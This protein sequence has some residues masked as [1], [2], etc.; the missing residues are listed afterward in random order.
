MEQD[1][2]GKWSWNASIKGCQEW[3]DRYVALVRDW[4]RF[5]GTTTRSP[6]RNVGRS[7]AAARRAKCA[8]IVAKL[9][10]LSRDVHFISGLMQERVPFV[11]AELG[12][13]V[14]PFILHLF[15]ALAEK[16]RA[17]ISRRTREALAA[18]KRRGVVLGNRELAVANRA[19]ARERAEALR[20]VLEELGDLSATAA[21]VEL[22]RRGVATPVGGR[23]HAMTVQRVRRRLARAC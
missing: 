4:N 17:L 14:D 16:E 6:L 7:L 20:P 3:H 11:V 8:I 15:A 12:N 13:D 21:A 1:D 9:D 18:A 23:W 22:N 2:S 19:T 10:R 5:V